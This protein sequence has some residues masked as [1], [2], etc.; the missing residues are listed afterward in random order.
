ME[1]QEE[2]VYR[3]KNYCSVYDCSDCPQQTYDGDEFGC[4]LQPETIDN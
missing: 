4:K 1:T 2:A 3:I